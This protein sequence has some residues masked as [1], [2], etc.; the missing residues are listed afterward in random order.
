[1]RVRTLALVVAAIIV[2][3]AAASCASGG[4]S[5]HLTV[6]SGRN[7][8]LIA[9]LIKDFET[10]TG[11]EVDVRYG[12]SA[13]LALLI[14]EEGK[15]APADVFLS[16]SPGAIGYLDGKNRLRAIDRDVLALVQERF[17]ADD[18]RWAGVSGRVRVLV[19]NTDLVDESD[20]PA[21][22]FDLTAAK[23]RGQVAVAPTNGSFQ[24]FITAM[25]ELE[26]DDK[27]RD[28]LDGMKA[29]GARSY[30]N[31]LAIV[32][33][34]GRGEIPMGLVNHYYLERAKAEDPSL[35]A[36]NYFFEGGDLGSLI[37]VTAAG[38]LDTADDPTDAQRLLEFML[39]RDAQLFYAKE[40]FEYPLARSVAPPSDLPALDAVESPSIDLS[41]LGG[42]L[43]ATRRLINES[44]LEQ[45]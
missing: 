5:Q 30:A 15:A 34:V 44:G 22:V 42:G 45:S 3:T 39:S 37:L 18:G 8:E 2:A 25:R 13:D 10:E 31:N 4:G 32:E 26:G 33:A 9:P 24:D 36:T 19:Y 16:Q 1:M 38:I 12:D 14:D 43:E 17:R 28:W 35:P 27:A 29:N 7:Q 6:Y 21:S 23:Y 41:S 11:I 40:T 20:L